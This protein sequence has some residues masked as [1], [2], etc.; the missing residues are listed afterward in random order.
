MPLDLQKTFWDKVLLPALIQ[1]LDVAYLL[2]MDYTVEEHQRKT[3]GKLSPDHYSG[4]SKAVNPSVLEKMIA[5]MQEIIKDDH[6][7][8]LLHQLGSFFFVLKAKGIKL[9]TMEHLMTDRNPW[10]SLVQEFSQLDFDYMMDPAHMQLIV[11]MGLSIN[12]HAN[13]QPIVELVRL[14]AVDGRRIQKETD[15][16]CQ[17]N[18][19]IW[20]YTSRNG[21]RNNEK[22]P[23][24]L[25]GLI[26]S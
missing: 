15:S 7:G 5:T 26:T 24:Y 3:A 18:G 20:S 10:K 17:H 23:H 11:D 4:I 22:N 14:D 25:Q 8:D 9:Y 2:Y 16:Q 21:V 6:H 13:S 12:P 19:P 1:H